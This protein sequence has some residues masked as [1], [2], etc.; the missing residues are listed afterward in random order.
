MNVFEINGVY[1]KSNELNYADLVSLGINYYN[2]TGRY[3]NSKNAYYKNGL[4]SYG[5]IKSIINYYGKT[6]EQYYIDMGCEDTIKVS[7]QHPQQILK[8]NY[9]DKF[10]IEL[11]D[12]T[13]LY[14][15]NIINSDYKSNIKYY[16]HDN[17]GYK[18]CV[19]FNTLQKCINNNKHP[20]RYL[21]EYKI[22]NLDNYMKLNNCVYGLYG[23]E[24][25]IIYL[26]S[27]DNRILKTTAKSIITNT[28][29]Y[30]KEGKDDYYKRKKSQECSKE[31]AMKNIINMQNKLGR[32]I[33]KEDFLSVSNSDRIGI[34]VI[35]KYWGNFI[36]MVKEINQYNC[37]AINNITAEEIITMAVKAKEDNHLK[38]FYSTIPE[39]YYIKVVNY[40]CDVV[41][42]RGIDYILY[43]DFF[44]IAAPF[45]YD[46]LKFHLNNFDIDIID[47]I[48]DRGIKLKHKKG[49]IIYKFDDGEKV[50][51]HNEYIFSLLL[52]EK[53]L[54]YNVDYFKNYKYSNVIKNYNG[55]KNFDYVLTKKDGQML[56][57]EI[58]GM[59]TN[60]SD[61][62]CFFEGCC[63][64]TKI[65]EQY[66]I[67]LTEKKILL[68]NS[69]LNYIF[70]MC[71]NINKE[72][73]SNIINTFYS[74]V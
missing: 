10:P 8:D 42:E 29:R 37:E 72:Y 9:T 12:G 68:D 46:S 30:T 25:D 66:R 52:R 47:L 65:K 59:L 13:T 23:V 2:R 34:S 11:E 7:N 45:K 32:Q 27:D 51:S 3:P 56:F 38:S 48:Q 57:V 67:Y 61:V 71:P 73:F 39:Q 17:Y 5:K 24:N 50:D 19:S 31:E 64:S 15:D 6:M 49:G 63:I 1:V 33:I 54:K 69:G 40:V 36:N 28:Y 21:G 60:V 53:G 16:I 74:N 4:P 35:E 26:I 22:F 18:Y 20:R 41:L 62:K 58:A 70:I 14:L 55:K 43:K 44:D